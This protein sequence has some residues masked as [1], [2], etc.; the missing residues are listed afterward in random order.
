VQGVA[1]ALRGGALPSRRD[2]RHDFPAL[3]HFA[4]MR[5]WVDSGALL[6]ANPIANFEPARALWAGHPFCP[7]GHHRIGILV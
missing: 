2:L 4:K 6:P 5:A 1:A 7:W 3:N